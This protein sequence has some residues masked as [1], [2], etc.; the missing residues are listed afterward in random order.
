VISIKEEVAPAADALAAASP[1]EP[2]VVKKGKT[3][4]AEAAA[5][6]KGAKK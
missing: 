1:A 5:P 4:T 3:E 6:E 2:E